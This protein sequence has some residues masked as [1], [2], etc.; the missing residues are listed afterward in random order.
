LSARVSA[1][2]W[3]FVPSGAKN[4]AVGVTAVMTLKLFELPLIVLREIDC[5]NG[6]SSGTSSP[7]GASTLTPVRF[8]ETWTVAFSRSAFLNASRALASV[9]LVIASRVPTEPVLLVG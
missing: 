9:S 2:F 1:N 8:V 3:A 7:A 4:F 6:E 5:L